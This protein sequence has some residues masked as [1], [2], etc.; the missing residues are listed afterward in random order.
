MVFFITFI[1]AIS[2]MIITN[3]H[4]T[5][6]YPTD[7]I[8]NGGLL[9]DV[10]FFA[11]SGYCLASVKLPFGKWCVKR[12]TRIYPPVII[13]T[14]VYF[15]LGFYKISGV[16]GFIKFFIYPTYYHFI[17]SILVLYIPFY[18]VMKLDAL[19]KRIPLV[20]L[21]TFLAE[22]IVYLTLFDRTIYHIDD[23]HSPMIRFLFFIAMLIGAYVKQNDEKYRNKGKARNIVIVI[24]LC[25]I[26]FA[27]KM[28]FVKFSSNSFIC[29]F[30]LLNQLVL[31]ALLYY[32]FIM[33][34]GIDEKLEKLPKWIKASVTFIST[35]TLEI[36]LV[37][38]AI[39]P[40]TNVL[41]F[42]INWII[43]T[44]TIAVSAIALH[45][46]SKFTISGIDRLTEKIS[47]NN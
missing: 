41:S 3:A 25:V 34:A 15:I 46:V 14:I 20:I 28:F 47:K 45:Y 9:G 35:M 22:L 23:V 16:T 18:L 32:V 29:Q 8:A 13:I 37:Q 19:K 7:L 30:Q 27:S 6:V 4:Y 36:Y 40:R 5:G 31:L 44:A 33:F 12:I 26:Y 10:L 39:I 43:I 24:A 38:Y 21:G 42:P 11:V 1:R 17:A 2:A